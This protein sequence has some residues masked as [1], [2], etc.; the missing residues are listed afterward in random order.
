MINDALGALESGGTLN[1][2]PHPCYYNYYCYH[3]YCKS[4]TSKSF[5][6]KSLKHLVVLGT[7][8]VE[9]GVGLRLGPGS[10][11]IFNGPCFWIEAWKLVF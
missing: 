1:A 7:M 5:M 9:F 3:F 11:T 4:C 8:G 2:C 6:Y 10:K